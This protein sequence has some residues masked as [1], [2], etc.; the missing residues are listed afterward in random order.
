MDFTMSENP[1]LLICECTLHSIWV[2]SEILVCA[3]VTLL[4]KRG[5]L[6]TWEMLRLEG[7]EV[8]LNRRRS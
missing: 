1:N 5:Q 8:V 6:L 3:L 4:G 7:L 2:V